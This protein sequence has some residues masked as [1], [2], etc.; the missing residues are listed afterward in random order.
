[1]TFLYA[2]SAL[3]PTASTCELQLRLPTAHKKYEH[4]QEYMVLGIKD[5][6]GF[7]GV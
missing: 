5:N 2:Q 4:F 3:L 7:G 1:M 6:D